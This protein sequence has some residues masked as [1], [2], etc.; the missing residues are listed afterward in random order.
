MLKNNAWSLAIVAIVAAAPTTARAITITEIID[1]NGDG[2]GNAQ[3]G[4]RSVAVDGS[5]NVYVAGES[6]DNAFKITPGGLITEIIDSSG[7]GAGN[8]LDVGTGVAVDDSGNVYVAGQFSNNAFKISGFGDTDGDGVLDGADNCAFVANGLAEPLGQPTWGDQAES[9]QFPGGGCAC[10][11]GDVNLDCVVNVLDS[12]ISSIAGLPTQAPHPAPPDNPPLP[13]SVTFFDRA[14]CDINADGACNVID[15][16]I[17]ATI[18]L[19]TQPVG[20]PFNNPPTP[21]GAPVD[22][23]GCCGYLGLDFGCAP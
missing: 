2:S 13:P 16:P 19:P 8:T 3:I 14:F 23:S 1:I 12:F 20:G 21:G 15:S 11:C 6:S 7:D 9:V 18:G 22:G 17:M 5:G 10:L 4:T